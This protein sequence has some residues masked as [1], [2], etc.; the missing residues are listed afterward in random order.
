MT[1]IKKTIEHLKELEAGASPGPWEH[2]I[3]KYSQEIKFSHRRSSYAFVSSDPNVK[4]IV[5]MRN[6]LPELLPKWKQL[7]ERAEK[8]EAE[9]EW[10]LN[11][12]IDFSYHDCDEDCPFED[13]PEGGCDGCQRQQLRECM[14]RKAANP[15]VK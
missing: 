13:E 11:H 5:A 8:A 15:V 3:Y 1:D 10:L 9:R 6:A 7:E 12:G 2:A 14:E 4:F